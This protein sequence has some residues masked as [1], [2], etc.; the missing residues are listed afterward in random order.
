MSTNEPQVVAL[1]HE[2][3]SA[4]YARLADLQRAS[5]DAASQQSHC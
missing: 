1:P 2:H 3:V 5:T 4:T